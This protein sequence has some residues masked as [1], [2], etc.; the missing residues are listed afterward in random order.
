MRKMNYSTA[1]FIVRRLVAPDAQVR[2]HNGGYRVYTHR[3]DTRTIYGEG[4]TYEEAITD[5][6]QPD[7]KPDEKSRSLDAPESVSNS[8][9]DPK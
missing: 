4:L 8:L 1:K 5:C 3:G 6:F 2:P 7:A 9:S